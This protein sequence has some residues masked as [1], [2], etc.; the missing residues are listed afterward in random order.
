MHVA[1]KK[2]GKTV[3]QVVTAL[4][5]LGNAEAVLCNAANTSPDAFREVADGL[6]AATHL[7]TGLTSMNVV[8]ALA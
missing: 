6:A 8:S 2:H 7:P 3:T 1:C 5:C 4:L